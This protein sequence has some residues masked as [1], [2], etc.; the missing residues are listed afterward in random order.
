M[1]S[2]F[3]SDRSLRALI[4][5]SGAKFQCVLGPMLLLVY[6]KLFWSTYLQISSIIT[7]WIGGLETGQSEGQ[8]YPLPLQNRVVEWIY[9]HNN[10]WKFYFKVILKTF[11]QFKSYITDRKLL[12]LNI[13]LLSMTLTLGGTDLACTSC[14][15]GNHL[16]QVILKP[17]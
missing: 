14:D 12:T 15:N 11:Q 17:F 13:W 4:Y 6:I 8:L 16:W 3:A 10:I 2:T 1:Y 9:F 5:F 7:K